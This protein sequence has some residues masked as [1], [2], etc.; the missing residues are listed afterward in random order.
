MRRV[1][2]MIKG[3]KVEFFFG[4]SGIPKVVILPGMSSSA[5]EWELVASQLQY[6]RFGKGCMCPITIEGV[7]QSWSI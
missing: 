4:G 1:I 2:E 3:K 5:Y 6:L 7:S